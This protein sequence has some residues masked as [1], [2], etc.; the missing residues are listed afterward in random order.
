M[1]TRFR[2]FSQTLRGM[3]FS[4]LGFYSSLST[5]SMFELNEAVRGRL[6]GP[7]TWDRIVENIFRN[8]TVRDCRGCYGVLNS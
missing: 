4:L 7:K 2:E 8:F 1:G 3:G 5:F 6:I